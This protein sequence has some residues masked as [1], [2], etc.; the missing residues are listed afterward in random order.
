M[1]IIKIVKNTNGRDC[2]KFIAP[3]DERLAKAYKLELSGLRFESLPVKGH[4]LPATGNEAQKAIQFAERHGFTVEDS[5]Q[6]LIRATAPA[7]KRASETSLK[8]LAAVDLTA[9][10]PDGRTLFQHQQT[11][12]RL[13]IE[14]AA[15]INADD[16]GLGKTLTAL[17]AA[18]GFQL[19]HN[20]R[21]IV[22]APIS[23]KD[24]WLREAAGVGVKIEVHSWAKTPEP[25]ECDYV[26]I[27]D[28]AHYAQS[29][30]SQRGEAFQKLAAKARAVFPLTGT[31]MKNGQPMNLFPLLVAVRHPLAKDQKHYEQRYCK[32]QKKK[33]RLKKVNKKGQR[34]ERTFYD[35][36]GAANLIELRNLTKDAILRRTK[37]QCLDLPAK[38]RIMRAVEGSAAAVAE[39]KATLQAKREEYEA[40]KSFGLFP[41]E[42]EAL[43]MLNV[44]RQ[45]ASRV[46]L[47]DAVEIAGELADQNQ[48]IV[49]FTAFIASAQT[50]FNECR[51]NKLKPELLT[52]DTPTTERQK[53][54]DRFQS[55]QSNV[56]VGTIQAGGVGLTLTKASTVVLIDRDWTPGNCFQAEDRVHRIGQ[57]WPVTAIWLRFG[58]FDARYDDQL[59]K[60]QQ[61]I[62]L[63]LEGERKTLRGIGGIDARDLLSSLLT[64][65]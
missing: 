10:L 38:T 2:I 58:A 54:V 49:L 56:F 59:L 35:A 22:L 25:P 17:V 48:Q 29:L 64:E 37:A 42:A 61:R 27:A 3:Y 21:V 18:K 20:W 60:K 32:A 41:E 47:A 8:A 23:L 9:P 43:A 40:M 12:A 14:S 15:M 7:L 16:M 50:L 51:K 53:I 52:G 24:N 13:M 34:I 19:A 65:F 6:R 44:I 1:R 30:R 46:K 63:V 5:V 57:H 31:P 39:Y 45:A 26:L 33:I 36:S 28:E 11:G 62:D 4:Y 55:G